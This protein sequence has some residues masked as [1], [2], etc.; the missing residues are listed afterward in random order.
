VLEWRS[1]GL[2][3]EVAVKAL[4]IE[5]PAEAVEA[6]AQRVAEILREQLPGRTSPAPMWITLEEAADRLRLSSAAARKRAQRGT[7][8]GAVKDP[9]GSRWLVDARQLTSAPVEATFRGDIRKRGERRVN[10]LAPGTEGET[11]DA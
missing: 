10:G 2:G 8:P 7:L 4:V 1:N 6:I 11:S 3:V 5:L 9:G